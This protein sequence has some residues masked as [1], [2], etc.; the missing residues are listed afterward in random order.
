MWKFTIAWL[1]LLALSACGK[2]PAPAADQVGRLP[3]MTMAVTGQP[4]STLIHVAEAK[5]YF[6]GEGLDM[7]F[8]RHQ[9]GKMALQ[10]VLERKADLA[11]AAETPIMFA[12]L[13][14]EKIFIIAN[15]EDSNSNNGVVAK[16]SS[17]I[18]TLADLKGKRIGFT[19]GTT[20]DFFLDSLLNV[21]GLSRR[22]ILPVELGPD[23]MLEA[24]NA[25]QVD[26]V[27]TW[28]YPLTQIAQAIGTAGLTF[29][30]RQIYT[31]TFNLVAQQDFAKKNPQLIE[32]FLRA[33]IRAQGF[34]EKEPAEAQAIMAKATGND[35]K[36]VRAVWANFN[37]RVQLDEIVLIS[38]EDETRWAVKNGLTDR[39]VMPNYGDYIYR[40]GL[41]S[42]APKAV[43]LSE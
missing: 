1:V 42:V 13:K 27:S 6:V 29:Q 24:L 35:I 43:K 10:A 3:K 38:L 4:Q 21:N 41:R 40:D 18:S 2:S 22:D 14:G 34:V 12:I 32:R 25:G 15:I 9:F 30:D 36:L 23:K 26:A 37:Y 31:E 39:T 5:G 11:G 17:G 19:K 28:N 8:Q 16:K 20:S 7:L 33:L